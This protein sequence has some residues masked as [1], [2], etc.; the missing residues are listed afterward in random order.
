MSSVLP[1]PRWSPLA[2]G[3]LLWA[4]DHRPGPTAES[5]TV[6]EPALT[7]HPAGTIAFSSNRDG[8]FEIYTM[9]PRGEDLTRLT[10]DPASDNDPDWSPDGTQIAFVRNGDIFVMKADGSD[11]IN[12]TNTLPPMVEEFPTWSPD[13]NQIAFDSNRDDPFGTSLY[14]MNADGSAPV[15][16]TTRAPANDISP[17][18]SSLGTIA[19]ERDLC[20]QQRWEWPSESHQS[21]GIR[22]RPELVGRWWLYRVHQRSG[23]LTVQLRHHQHGDRWESPEKSYPQ[24]SGGRCDA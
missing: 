20:D 5:E 11:H 8:N 14:V 3:W 16:I 7:R 6:P 22:F 4:C 13:G 15:R 12:L 19:F 9:G 18:W 2:F 10:N 1:I 17:A 21:P 23:H 24:E